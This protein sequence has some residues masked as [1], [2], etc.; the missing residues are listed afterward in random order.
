MLGRVSTRFE[1]AFHG[2]LGQQ[3]GVVHQR[4]DR[5]D[6]LVQVVLQRVEVAVVG[7]GDLR[8]DVALGDAV[9]VACGHVQRADHRVQRVVHAL[10]DLLEVALVFGGIGT[11][12]EL[13]VDRGLGQHIRVGDHGLHGRLHAAHGVRQ[14]AD[15]VLAVHVQREF[16]VA[17]GHF[18][19]AFYELVGRPRDGACDDP[20]HEQRQHGRHDAQDQYQVLGGVDQQIGVLSD[21]LHECSLEVDHVVHRLVVLVLCPAQLSLHQHDDLGLLV[22]LE[23]LQEPVLVHDIGRARGLDL[24]QHLLALVAGDALFEFFQPVRNDLALLGDRVDRLLLFRAAV[25]VGVAQLARDHG[26][27]IGDVVGLHGLR[28]LVLHKVIDLCVQ[29][30][31][32]GIADHGDDDQQDQR[33]G[34]ADS[35]PDSDFEVVQHG[36]TP[37][38]RN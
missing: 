19:R 28:K 35:Q 9:H 30:R 31:Q 34:K 33:D 13:A 24:G 38:L 11:R 14:R 2:R 21:F 16:E 32:P 26:D 29:R 25:D 4:V 22:C 37:D 7:V 27:G 18:V 23:Q 8:R 6:G 10:D 36:M 12:L 15:L 20:A 5:V 3:V 17:G 1:L